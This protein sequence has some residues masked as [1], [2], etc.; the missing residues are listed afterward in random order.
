[1]TLGTNHNRKERGRK[2]VGAT[3]EDGSQWVRQTDRQTE[4]ERET[5]TKARWVGG[6]AA[7]VRKIKGAH[8]RRGREQV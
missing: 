6:G 2:L 3:D 5:G 4:T 7:Q 8:R 1:M